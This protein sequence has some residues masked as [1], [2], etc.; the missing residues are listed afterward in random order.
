[1][2][3]RPRQPRLGIADVLL[4]IVWGFIMGFVIAHFFFA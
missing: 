1:M 3:S 4:G 2:V